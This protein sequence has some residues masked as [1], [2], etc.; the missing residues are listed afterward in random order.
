MQGCST[1]THLIIIFMLIS[2]SI[3]IC[4]FYSF[5]KEEKLVALLVNSSFGLVA[6]NGV[7]NS[8]VATSGL[9]EFN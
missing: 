2:S 8:S 9:V 5:R 7:R 4:D 6:P 3:N 1:Q